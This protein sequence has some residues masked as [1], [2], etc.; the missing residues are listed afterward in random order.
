M[1]LISIR[2]IVTITPMNTVSYKAILFGDTFKMSFGK[3]ELEMLFIPIWG[4]GSDDLGYSEIDIPHQNFDHITRSSSP[5]HQFT[6]QELY[7]LQI[8]ALAKARKRLILPLSLPIGNQV[9]LSPDR[10][11]RAYK[12]QTD[13]LQAEWAIDRIRSILPLSDLPHLSQLL[14][15]SESELETVLRSNP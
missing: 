11:L 8:T 13:I 5:D 1:H 10:A 7:Q 15:N 6:Y 2:R 9:P 4:V 12:L 14:A 3:D